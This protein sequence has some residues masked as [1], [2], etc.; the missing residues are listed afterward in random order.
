MAGKLYGVGIGP[1]DPE[2]ITIKARRI[3]AEADVVAVPKTAAEKASFAQTIAEGAFEKG[4]E[5][6]ELLFPMSFD[7]E[8]L[9]RSWHEAIGQIREKLELGK[10]V[11]FITLGDPTVYST[12]M[13][14][15]KQ[16]YQEGYDTE[17]I[18][19]VTSFCAAAA[20]AG[21]SLGENRETIAIVPS[22]YE[23]N[24]LENILKSFD[25]IILMKLSK[26]LPKLKELLKSEGL[27]ESAVLV[28]KCGLED[29]KITYDLNLSDDEKISYFSTMLVKKGGVR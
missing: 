11:A 27:S 3:L 20:R 15:H 7:V 29:E 22:A 16:L 4:K 28:S 17:I 25:N 10:T 21:I 13:Y 5:L 12:Y 8:V 14:I 2:L 18:P 24:N 9:E 19:G 1:G 6:L 23:C 26:S